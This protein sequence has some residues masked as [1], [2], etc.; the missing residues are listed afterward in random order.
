MTI[1]EL[2]AQNQLLRQELILS[3]ANTQRLRNQIERNEYD[4]GKQLA[5]LE[6]DSNHGDDCGLCMGKCG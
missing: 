1:D 2:S 5:E 6:R 4:I 3:E